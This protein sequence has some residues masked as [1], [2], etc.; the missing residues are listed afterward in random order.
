V[1]ASK[2]EDFFFADGWDQMHAHANTLLRLY[3]T[4]RGRA[5]EYWG[6]QHIQNDRMVH[7]LGLPAQAD[8]A[9]NNQDPELKT[10]ISSYVAGIN[11][12]AN[13]NPDAIEDENRVVLPVSVKDVNLH[14][15]FVANTRFVA[16]GEQR[17]SQRWEENGSNAFAVS[18]TKSESGN[19]MLVQNPHLPW[20]GE[21]LWME[22]H[23]VLPGHNIYGANLVGFPGFAI[24]FNDHLGWTHTNNTM[25]GSDL[26]ELTLENDGYHFDGEIRSFDRETVRL[27]V[28]NDRNELSDRD[29]EVLN[30]VH[31]PVVRI[32][33]DKAL[34][35]RY[36]GN[37]AHNSFLQWWHMAKAN[38]FESFESAL[39]MA[40]IPYWNVLYADSTGNIFYVFN[41]HVPVRNHGDWNY[42]RGVIPG[43]SS[44]N[45][46]TEVHPYEDLPKLFNP[47]SGWLQ[48]AND[49]PWTSTI[50]AELDADDYPSYMAPRFMHFRPQR[51]AI[52]MRD[53]QSISFDEL[54]DYKHDTRLQMADRILDDLFAAIDTFGTEIGQEAKSVLEQW[55]RKA[56]ND[57]RGT[58][59]FYN[60]A[61][62]IN[63]NNPGIYETGWDEDFPLTT[64][65]GLADPETAVKVLEG[66]AEKM[67][68][69][70]GRLDVPWGEVN[71]INYNGINLP[72]NGAA[73]AVGV[74]RV[75][76]GGRTND[77]IQTIRH[78]DSWVAVVEFGETT[79][80]KV[81]VSYG[82]S[83][84]AG[85][86]HYGDQ[87][88]LF[89]EKKLRDAWRT[90]EQLK[91]NI[92][93]TEVLNK[94]IF[95]PEN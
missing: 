49:P 92:I 24:A 13:A 47:V 11:A 2:D 56:E 29:I 25:D 88:K 23:V 53:D 9:W 12:Y 65:D 34:A 39:K 90:H 48:N 30:S 73:G 71:R 69:Q 72:S 7:T 80:A 44:A 60:W 4:S 26:Y 50:P 27:K 70:Y 40:Q 61:L 8:L 42:W 45:L 94:G 28:K 17:Q 62:T 95:Q 58:V 68:Q 82:N 14:A 33:N 5:A 31:G 79:R 43:D 74:F 78:G 75:A 1:F 76:A 59:L 86:P 54:V 36:V 63:P 66:V 21:F 6:D 67:K 83:T 93:R 41:G 55:D 51:A 91:G 37:D 87:L 64:P 77:G 38:H 46:W 22:K 81:L 15:L 85:S 19:A 18:P 84:Q 3:G 20:S 52:M 16:G 32:G 10:L 35:L 89:S 57:S